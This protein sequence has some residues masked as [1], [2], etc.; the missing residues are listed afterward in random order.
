MIT[1]DKKGNKKICID[2]ESLRNFVKKLHY[3]KTAHTGPYRLFLLLNNNFHCH[4]MRKIIRETIK[5]CDICQRIKYSNMTLHGK[6]ASFQIIEP[7]HSVSCD[8]LGPICKSTFGNRY[9]LILQD[10][11]SKCCK[12]YPLKAT[13]S[14]AI[15][16]KIKSLKYYKQI[17][18][19]ITQVTYLSRDLVN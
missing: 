5:V 6:T 11:Y 2:K 13:T 19:H 4:K 14:K 16:K 12:I 18:P 7:N 17:M 9:I 10:M 1:K 8:V 3:E 15:L